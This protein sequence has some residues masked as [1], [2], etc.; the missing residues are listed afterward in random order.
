M[1]LCPFYGRKTQ[2]EAEELC[3]RPTQL[4]EI[5]EEALPLPG[6]WRAPGTSEVPARGDHAPER[7]SEL[8]CRLLPRGRVAALAKSTQ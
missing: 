7:V 3:V 8:R 4:T 5:P 1:F 2:R 6:R